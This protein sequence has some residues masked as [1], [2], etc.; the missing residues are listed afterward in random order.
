MPPAHEQD[1]PIEETPIGTGVP[2]LGE[3]SVVT[4][5]RERLR[6]WRRRR[7]W[8]ALK[9]WEDLDRRRGELPPIERYRW[10]MRGEWLRRRVEDLGEPQEPDA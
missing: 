5:V 7:A 9:Q 3:D 1:A 6:E 8:L 2:G 10:N 4:L